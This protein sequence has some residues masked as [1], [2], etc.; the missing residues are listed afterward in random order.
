[1]TVPVG[2]WRATYMPG[3]E[4]VLSGPTSLVL[5]QLPP[6]E[7]AAMITALWEEVVSSSSM[8]D[9]AARLATFKI[10]KLPS[11]GALFWTDDGMRSLVRGSVTITD[12]ST[13]RVVADGAGIQTW[14]EVG[15][16]ALN[17]CLISAGSNRTDTV[18][19]PLVVGAVRAS[20]IILD[21]TQQALVYSPQ[22]APPEAPEP[23]PSE[24]V[25]AAEAAAAEA[26]TAEAAPAGVAVAGVAA[27]EAASAGVA[28]EVASSEP[29]AEPLPEVESEGEPRKAVA[30]AAPP[31]PTTPAELGKVEPPTA[32]MDMAEQL[33]TEMGMVEQPT[34][35]MDMAEQL[36]AELDDERPTAEMP[37]ADAESAASP[38]AGDQPDAEGEPADADSF[39]DELEYADTQLMPAPFDAFD[40]QP[41]DDAPPAFPQ[42]PVP[43]PVVPPTPP[44]PPAAPSPIPPP[45]PP[46]IPP[47]PSSPIPPPASS[48][49]PPPPPPPPPP[50]T[51]PTPAMPVFA[52]SPVDPMI[53]AVECP[54]GHSNPPESGACRICGTPIQPQAPRLV[55][56]PVL[57]VLFASDGSTAELDRAVLVG[58]APDPTKSSFKDPRLLTV[59]SPGHD[60]SRTHVQVAPDGWQIVVTDLQSTNGTTLIRPGG[61]DQHRL[62]PGEPVPVQLGSVLELGDG[63]S[64]TI[65]V[66]Q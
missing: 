63:V 56:R 23:A 43:E 38:S 62:P 50:A 48:P 32:E 3:A 1:M 55:G 36:A 12:L 45:P 59:Q 9:L 33:A 39:E 16:G 6:S 21:A 30:M 66:P 35:E 64:V 57:A 15:L 31:V 65:G 60:I 25:A 34:A 24:E 42:P 22:L 41:F 4:I 44:I 18:G 26:A 58:R 11:F 29:V 37:S 47:A 52:P 14:S 8:A 5:V 2:H 53:M 46:P 19:L 7:Q 13:G 54:Y 20:S 49:I 40:P 27:G 51:A 17:R 28:A 10:D 61:Y